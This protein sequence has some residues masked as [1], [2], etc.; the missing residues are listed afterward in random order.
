M[1]KAAF[2]VALLLF[3]PFKPKPVPNTITIAIKI[4]VLPW[5]CSLAIKATKKSL[6]VA[7]QDA[8]MRSVDAKPR[9]SALAGL[10][11]N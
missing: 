5:R 2:S 7:L 1:W 10:F 3:F 4:F 11:L 9:C 8:P 6:A